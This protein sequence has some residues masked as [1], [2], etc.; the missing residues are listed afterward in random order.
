M[1]EYIAQDLLKLTSLEA[2]ILLYSP[3]LDLH[4]EKM[5]QLADRVFLH[6][7]RIGWDKGPE[8]G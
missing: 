2:T 5:T 1:V 4:L 8:E 6:L 7:Q 3:T